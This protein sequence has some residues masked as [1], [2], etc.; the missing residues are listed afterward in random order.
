M[1]VPRHRPLPSWAAQPAMVL[2]WTWVAPAAE[3]KAVVPWRITPGP[4]NTVKLANEFW[5][6][7]LSGAALTAYSG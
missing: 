1:P 7:R 3:V 4:P 6:P 5:L 2:G